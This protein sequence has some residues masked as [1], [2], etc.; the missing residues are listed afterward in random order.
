[1]N[2][3]EPVVRAAIYVLAAIGY[4][5]TG[6][7]S[8]VSRNDD[9]TFSPTKLGKTVAVGAGAGVIMA[10]RGDD[11]NPEAYAAAAAIAIPI[12]DELLNVAIERTQLG[13]GSTPS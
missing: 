12:V 2:D 8:K 7:L 11:V 6:Y 10:A 5:V 13:S 4:G 3:Q 9:V 1:M